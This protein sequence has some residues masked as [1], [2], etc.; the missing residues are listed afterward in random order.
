MIRDSRMYTFRKY[1]MTYHSIAKITLGALLMTLAGCKDSPLSVEPSAPARSE[2]RSLVGIFD[3]LDPLYTEQYI[4]YADS[5][6]ILHGNGGSCC[7]YPGKY[8]RADSAITFAFDGVA[9]DGGDVAGPWMAAGIVR[10]D[11]LVVMYNDV[12]NGFGFED[13]VYIRE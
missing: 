8:S 3:R 7:S 6:F 11:S 12:M 10:G 9:W 1:P 5:T 13:G 2:P 4:L